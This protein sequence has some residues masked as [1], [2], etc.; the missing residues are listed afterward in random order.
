MLL[1][2]ADGKGMKQVLT[3]FPRGEKASE[4]TIRFEIFRVEGNDPIAKARSELA[5]ALASRG[6]DRYAGAQ[7]LTTKSGESVFLDQYRTEG[8]RIESM[9]TRYFKKDDMIVVYRWTRRMPTA[10]VPAEAGAKHLE[11]M[12]FIERE[13]QKRVDLITDFA[14]KKDIP[15]MSKDDPMGMRPLSAKPKSQP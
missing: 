10:R 14:T 3:Y 7:L 2:S 5:E 8:E 9:L 15:H 4:W 12:R 11:I 1:S 13:R 6:N